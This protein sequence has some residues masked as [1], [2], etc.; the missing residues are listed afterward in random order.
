[1]VMANKQHKQ[2]KQ[3]N[4]SKDKPLGMTAWFIAM[5][6]ELPG[7]MYPILGFS[8]VSNVLL[9]VSPLYML[10]VYDRILTSGSMDTLIWITVISVFLLGIYAA[11]EA[12]RRRICGIAAE[13]LDEVISERVFTQ[14]D[15]AHDAGARL[16]NDLRVLSRIRGFFQ[17]QT[18]LPFFDLPFAPFFLLVMFLIHPIIGTLGLIGGLILLGVAISAEM[19]NRKTNDDASSHSSQ[20]FSL[21]T[22]VSRQRSAIVSMG[23]TRGALSKWRAA[24]AQA[25]ELNMKAGAR[26][27]GFA[28]VTRAGRQM[29]QVLILG[30]GGALAITQQISPGA[31]VAGSIILSRALG[32]ID[33]IVGS[34]RGI[35]SARGAWKQLSGAIMQ[36]ET[37]APFTPL[38]RPKA[39]LA[40]SRLCVNVPG[41]KEPLIR[42]FGFEAHGGQMIA[43]LGGNGSGKTS[44]LQTLA[45]AYTPHSGA[46]MLGGRELHRWAAEDRGQ[47]VGYVP[48]MIELLPGTVA[49]NIA[50]MTQASPEA[51]IEAATLAGAHDMILGLPQGY[52]T[53]VGVPGM[54]GLSAGQ[55]Q[56]VGLAR[57]I[58]GNPVLI[59]LDEPTANL[60]P[61]AA[62]HT[63]NQLKA[64]AEA[65]AIVIAATHDVKLIQSTTSVM[66]VREGGVLAADTSRYLEAIKPKAENTA[67]RL[68]AVGANS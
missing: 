19:T 44:L 32:P 4:D 24:K 65:G 42:P 38:P 55:R 30:A 37:K 1:M 40:L 36:D 27:G 2:H 63:I 45:G 56:L 17:N 28:S 60:D 29:L 5:H 8:L 59:I 68:Q 48:Q 43:V 53:E 35:A 31:I 25:R 67:T 62:A 13:H 64:I 3:R 33:Q 23:L 21:A 7:Y 50:R 52:E 9:L 49:E 10:Q 15:E 12:G 66:V 46:V 22:G 14:F 57:A 61:A 18:V 34:W 54:G 16:P 6:R 58:F 41:R 47:Y 11:A 39:H 51:I 20:A 26:E